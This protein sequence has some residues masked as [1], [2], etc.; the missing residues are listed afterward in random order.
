MIWVPMAAYA[1]IWVDT[2]ANVC[3]WVA[4]D[5]YWIWVHMVTIRVDMGAYIGETTKNT[6]DAER[7]PPQLEGDLYA[8]R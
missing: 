7:T 1:W 4:M 3:T 2:G 5:I 8:T 6:P